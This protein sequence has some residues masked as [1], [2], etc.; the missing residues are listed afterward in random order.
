M[1]KYNSRK[2]TRNTDSRSSRVMKIDR[3]KLAKIGDDD[4]ERRFRTVKNLVVSS[5]FSSKKRRELEVELCYLHR[6]REIRG[7]R[8]AAHQQWLKSSAYKRRRA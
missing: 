5:K 2:Q 8:R 6:E 7:A 4:L 1:V 3:D